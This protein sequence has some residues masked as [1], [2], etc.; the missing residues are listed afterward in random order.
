[1]IME[2]DSLQLV[3]LWNSRRQQLSE[4]AVILQDIEEMRSANNVAHLCAKQASQSRPSL[5]WQD[6][7]PSFLLSSLRRDCNPPV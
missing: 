6:H 4:I 5:L 1:M 2:T 7:P 3:S